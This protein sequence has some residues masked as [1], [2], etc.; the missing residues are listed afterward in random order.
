M[1]A[2]SPNS[3]PH[4]IRLDILLNL[5]DSGYECPEN[6]GIDEK[7]LERYSVD[8]IRNE[9]NTMAAKLDYTLDRSDNNNVCIDEIPEANEKIQYHKDKSKSYFQ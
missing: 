2:A 7:E 1:A 8:A 3:T 4:G 6:I 9:I 5:K